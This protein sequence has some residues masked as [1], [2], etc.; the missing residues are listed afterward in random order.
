MAEAASAPY[1][2]ELSDRAVAA[3]QRIDRSVAQRLVARLTW[4]S[5]N[6]ATLPHIA[7][8]GQFR[9]LFKLRVGDYRIIYALD[10]PARTIRV[11]LIGHRRDIYED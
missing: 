7:L 8:T 11:A 5:A 6:A 2:V 1:R 3:L 9:G 10:H 4:L